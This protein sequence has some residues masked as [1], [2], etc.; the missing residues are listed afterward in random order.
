[1]NEIRFY[2]SAVC[3]V[4]RQ[5]ECRGYKKVGK[6]CHYGLPDRPC[7]NKTLRLEV[8]KRALHIEQKRLSAA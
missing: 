1:M 5:D 6:W 3:N 4:Y 7:N 8:F 2:A